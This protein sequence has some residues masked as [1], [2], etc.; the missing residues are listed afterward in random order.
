MVYNTGIKKKFEKRS[1]Q[2]IYSWEIVI[3]GND[4]GRGL[5]VLVVHR[6]RWVGFS[7]ALIF[8]VVI[9][10]ILRWVR[11]ALSFS[12]ARW[13]GRRRR[14]FRT[15]DF[16]LLHPAKPR[17]SQ[18]GRLY[19]HKETKWW[20]KRRRKKRKS[21]VHHHANEALREDTT[22]EKQTKATTKR[23]GRTNASST[24]GRSSSFDSLSLFVLFCLSP[25][26]LLRAA[27]EGNSPIIVRRKRKERIFLWSVPGRIRQWP[28]SIKS[29]KAVIDSKRKQKILAGAKKNYV[30]ADECK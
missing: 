30:E 14:H 2:S 28:F 24:A 11:W 9:E 3:G 7:R 8:S 16:P 10:I 15:R 29:L 27:D 23:S 22:L 19:N 18:T 20:K 13:R 12:G 6:S 1:E 25:A 4:F 26:V 21:H 17:I 5:F